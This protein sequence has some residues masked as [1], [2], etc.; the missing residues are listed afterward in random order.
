MTK[1]RYF[2]IHF[3]GLTED[4]K[5][6][7]GKLEH[8]MDNGRYINEINIMKHISAMFGLEN[9]FI[10]HVT[11]IAESDFMDWTEGRSKG[12]KGNVDDM[13]DDDSVG[14]L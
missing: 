10:K 11:E 4:N 3:S 5:L 8:R 7:N 9:V 6:R 14:F 1:S 13:G 2:M 12:D